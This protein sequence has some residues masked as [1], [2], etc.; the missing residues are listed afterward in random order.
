[1]TPAPY[2]L[3]L[4]RG[5]TYAW[6]FVL[7]DDIAQTIP[8]DLTGVTVKAEI[9]DQ[10]AGSTIVPLNLTVTLPNL[11]YAALD[12]ASSQK[13]PFPTGVWD[14][15]LTYPDATVAT[16]IAGTVLV[17]ADVTDSSVVASSTMRLI[18]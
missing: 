18:K 12:A 5:D 6:Q 9:R 10:P 17:T 8:T 14:L 7:W 11:I 1:M 16:P 15:Q 13:L 2:P 3:V 4:Y